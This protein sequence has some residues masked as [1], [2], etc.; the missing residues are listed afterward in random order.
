MWYYLAVLSWQVSWLYECLY[1][2]QISQRSAALSCMQSLFLGGWEFISHGG[3]GTAPV[4]WCSPQPG[5]CAAPS[6]WCSQCLCSPSSCCVLRWV[7]AGKD[8]ILYMEKSKYV[9]F[10]WL[11]PVQ[12]KNF[13]FWCFGF[14]CCQFSPITMWRYKWNI[15][16]KKVLKTHLSSNSGAL[17]IPSTCISST[18]FLWD[19]L[20]WALLHLPS[21]LLMSRFAALCICTG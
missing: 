3:P 7:V 16:G 17:L 10:K 4:R 12:N 8:P 14:S 1:I 9:V 13:R 19:P 15:G 6:S 11:S 5:N 21:P 2:K 20:L 18:Q